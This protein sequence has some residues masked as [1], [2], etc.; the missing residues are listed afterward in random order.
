MAA[1]RSKSRPAGLRHLA[2][3]TLRDL[4]SA[5]QLSWLQPRLGGLLWML[6]EAPELGWV[7]LVAPSMMIVALLLNRATR[8]RQVRVQNL[9]EW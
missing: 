7:I 9:E 2:S 3:N 5:R 8:D 1:E 6:Q 4:L